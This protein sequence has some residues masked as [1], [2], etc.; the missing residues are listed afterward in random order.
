MLL[1]LFI[2]KVPCVIET[3][4]IDEIVTHIWSVGTLDLRGA[5]LDMSTTSAMLTH[6]QSQVFL[7]KSPGGHRHV[8]MT[9]SRRNASLIVLPR[10][11]KRYSVTTTDFGSNSLR[12]LRR[13]ST[14]LRLEPVTLHVSSA[15][16]PRSRLHA[17]TT[18]NHAQPSHQ[19]DH[20]HP[21]AVQCMDLTPHFTTSTKANFAWITYQTVTRSKMSPGRA[22]R[23]FGK[24]ESPVTKWQCVLLRVHLWRECLVAGLC[25]LWLQVRFESRSVQGSLDLTDRPESALS[26]VPIDQFGLHPARKLDHLSKSA[27]VPSSRLRK[28]QIGGRYAAPALVR[29]E[30]ASETGRGEK[31]LPGVLREPITELASTLQKL[32]SVITQMSNQHTH[33]TAESHDIVCRQQLSNQVEID[34]SGTSYLATEDLTD[35]WE[36][37]QPR[38]VRQALRAVIGCEFYPTQDDGNSALAQAQEI[39][40]GDEEV[41]SV[42][43]EPDT[44]E[45]PPTG[46]SATVLELVR[47]THVNVGHPSPCPSLRILRAAGARLKV[48]AYVRHPFQCAVCSTI[49]RRASHSRTALLVTYEFK[50]TVAVDLFLLVEGTGGANRGR[51]RP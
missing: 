25:V 15:V 42:G 14:P 46:I 5:V 8:S 19:S 28:V 43:E 45:P 22:E 37:F 20:S 9:M 44:G 49:C 18:R 31:K 11:T 2:G 33:V 12:I 7:H 29:D 50:N 6:V 39:G 47:K 24:K 26:S 1:P 13:K 36:C 35:D 27:H 4:L 32:V 40:Q 16:H 17:S 51:V 30:D 3:T 23:V 10:A 48:L 21:S 34:G 41:K 38:Q